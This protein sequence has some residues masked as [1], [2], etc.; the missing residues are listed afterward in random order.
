MK[1]VLLF[2]LYLW[3]TTTFQSHTVI[4]KPEVVLKQEEATTLTPVEKDLGIKE[5]TKDVTVF[6]WAKR[7]DIGI[8]EAGLVDPFA[9]ELKY[10]LERK[11]LRA[12]ELPQDLFGGFPRAPYLN[13]T[14]DPKQLRERGGAQDGW[15][16]VGVRLKKGI[17]YLDLRGKTNDKI[18]TTLLPE[19]SLTVTNN[20]YY[21]YGRT[22]TVSTWQQFR[23]YENTAEVKTKL[24]EILNSLKISFLVVGEV[25]S[26]NVLCTAARTNDYYS[27]NQSSAIIVL[28]SEGI[29]FGSTYVLVKETN[30]PRVEIAKNGVRQFFKL[31][32][33]SGP[34]NPFALKPSSSGSTPKPAFDAATEKWVREELFDCVK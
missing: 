20:S 18:P 23:Q 16:L 29:D 31:S 9:G 7:K 3:M 19:G 32:K 24:R 28:D 14:I 33:Q 25:A 13:S 6:H 17:R 11:V 21:S 10:Y 2:S 27:S 12:W 30:D 15:A 8:P 34:N 22:A 4:E 26:S 1:S 5:L